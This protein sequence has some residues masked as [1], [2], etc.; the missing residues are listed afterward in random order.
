MVRDHGHVV[1]L[2]HLA[3]TAAATGGRAHRRKERI[4]P[5]SASIAA[6][7][8]LR[9]NLSQ[10]APAAVAAPSAVIDLSTYERAARGR[11]T[12]S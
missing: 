7:D 10:T 5:G 9:S 8:A 11:N 6:A 1:A 12:L 3:M 2:D 4:P